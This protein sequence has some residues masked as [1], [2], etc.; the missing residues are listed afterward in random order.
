VCGPFFAKFTTCSHFR[1]DFR[2]RSGAGVMQ[3]QPGEEPQKI[4]APLLPIIEQPEPARVSVMH[5]F[6]LVC[7]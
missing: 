7:S 3:Q 4:V 1:A 2:V 5:G 6:I